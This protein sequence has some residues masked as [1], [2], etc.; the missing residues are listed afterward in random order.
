MWKLDNF[1]ELV[2]SSRGSNSGPQASKQALLPIEL[3]HLAM[4]EILTHSKR[5]KNLWSCGVKVGKAFWS[6]SQR[7]MQSGATQVNPS[8]NYSEEGRDKEADSAL[9][10]GKDS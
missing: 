1:Q 2:F 3:C 4:K 9:E 7:G 8:K 5:E 10:E 6:L